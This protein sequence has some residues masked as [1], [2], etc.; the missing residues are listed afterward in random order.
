MRLNF[1]CTDQTDIS[2][3]ISFIHWILKDFSITV[4]MMKLVLENGSTKGSDIFQAV[5]Q[6][7]MEYVEFQKRSNIVTNT[8][9]FFS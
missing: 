9:T 8:R 4:E 7:F 5:K 3:L 2:R 6:T 1:K